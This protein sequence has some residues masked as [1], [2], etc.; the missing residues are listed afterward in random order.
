MNLSNSPL[1]TLHYNGFRLFHYPL[2]PSY[3]NLLELCYV[4]NIKDLLC[5][6]QFLCK[7]L[8]P[9]Y[10]KNLFDL[11]KSLSRILMKKLPYRIF[12]LE[13]VC[14][15]TEQ[16]ILKRHFNNAENLNLEYSFGCTIGSTSTF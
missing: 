2:S 8:F 12:S 7:A 3:F 1:F 11:Y 15:K 16:N 13:R 9:F 6:I 5:F 4:V 10:L 14:F